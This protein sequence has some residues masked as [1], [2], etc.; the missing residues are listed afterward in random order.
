MFA[1]IFG[2][3]VVIAI[4][5][6]LVN[7]YTP[8]QQ[9]I[10]GKIAGDQFD[11]SDK[12]YLQ[13][14]YLFNL[15]SGVNSIF[16]I[17]L[18]LV[19][20]A[21]WINPAKKAWAAASAAAIIA[22]M[23]NVG[24]SDRAFAFAQQTDKTEVILILPNHSA[25]WVP[26]VG[27]N[28]DSQAEFDS[29]SYYN[30]RKI[31]AKMF[32]IPHFK[33]AGSNG[34]SWSSGWDY[35]VPTGRLFIVDRSPITRLWVQSNKRGTS[36]SDESFPC[37]TSEG[38]NVTA[39]VAIGLYVTEADAAKYLF[40]FGVIQP[41]AGTDLE[42]PQVIFQSV[43]FGRPL[44]DVA[45]KVIHKEVAS[46]VCNEIES[47]SLDQV[48]SQMVPMMASIEANV[49]K[50]LALEGIT[51]DFIGWADTFGFD[52][53]IQA[54]IND[55]FKTEKLASSMAI[56]NALAMIDVQK[57]LGKGL[58]NHGL[59]LAITPGMMEMIGSLVP[60]PSIPDL[61]KSAVAPQK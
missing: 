34:T 53:E 9:L 51:L 16:L 60:R 56:L 28:K 17:G 46:L 3:A 27:N 6:F 42:D 52:Q 2:S 55:K 36:T 57:G 30:E 35:Y 49:R 37:Q 15:L 20:F 41:K 10:S 25:F 19:L 45:D 50:H 11:A 14:T 24:S 26:N 48:N 18:V 47:R 40:H 4:Y 1:R 7:M 58:E 8:V 44:D 54:S 38:L 13:T 21:I 61:V 39:G 29:E 31:A 22:F 33:L 5:G 59:P 32:T 12:A 23:V 43:Y